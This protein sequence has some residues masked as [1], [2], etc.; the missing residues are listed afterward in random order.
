MKI[1]VKDGQ[2][3]YDV[4]I[5]YYGSINQLQ[6]LFDDNELDNDSVLYSGQ[7]LYIQDNFINE[8][9]KYFET[10]S[11]NSSD[12]IK[13]FKSL[14]NEKPVIHTRYEYKDPYQYN[15]WT[16]EEGQT[17]YDITTMFYGSPENINI[18]FDDNKGLDYNSILYSGQKLKLSFF[19]ND[20]F[21][22]TNIINNI[23][24]NTDIEHR[25]VG[26]FRL[27][28][29]Q[30]NPETPTSLG[31]AYLEVL[32]GISPY[33]YLWSRGDDTLNLLSAHTGNYTITVTDSE[34]NE[35]TLN[36]YI[37]FY[38]EVPVLVKPLLKGAYFT[39]PYD[40]ILT[41][42]GDRILINK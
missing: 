8:I 17:V 6:L 18:L 22:N 1:T 34:N 41:S 39:G 14:E 9:T 36:I 3:I 28:V 23:I 37:P 20:V 7:I 5:Q 12:N 2:T 31:F 13:E 24:N 35:I 33:T 26:E 4:A 42:N 32:G 27:N 10:K 16:V 21:D 30:V 40:A 11:V 29:L 38:Q 25:Y 19:K 15:E